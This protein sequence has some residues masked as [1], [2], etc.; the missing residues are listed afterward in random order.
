MSKKNENQLEF[1]SNLQ[2]PKVINSQKVDRFGAK[3]APIE[4]DF[5][6]FN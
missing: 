2:K 3:T 1:G 6:S 4:S 5:V